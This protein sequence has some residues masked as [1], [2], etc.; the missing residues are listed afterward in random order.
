MTNLGSCIKLMNFVLGHTDQIWRRHLHILHHYNIAKERV[1]FLAWY[2]YLITYK[3]SFF[4][5]KK[6][7]L[8]AFKQLFYSKAK[9]LFISF[10]SQ[11]SLLIHKTHFVC[12]PSWIYS[13]FFFYFYLFVVYF[14]RIATFQINCTTR[15]ASLRFILHNNMR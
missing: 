1:I 14:L 13:G 11:C 4:R 3:Q 7:W 12:C 8:L 9:Q 15:G 2:C 5:N 10:Y 6:V